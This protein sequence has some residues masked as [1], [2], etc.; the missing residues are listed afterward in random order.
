MKNKRNFPE[1][2]YSNFNLMEL[3]LAIAIVAATASFIVPILGGVEDESRGN[4]VKYE[5]GRLREAFEKLDADCVLSDD[6]LLDASRYGLWMLSRR[7]HPDDPSKD[8][9]SYDPDR[10]RGWRGPYA[11]EE[12]EVAVDSSAPGQPEDASAGVNVPVFKDPYSGY[13]RVL[14]PRNGEPSRIALVCVG[15]DGTLDTTPD[16]VD[17]FG[18]LKAGGDDMVVRLL[19][20]R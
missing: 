5:M 14:I 1:G 16:D 13:Y 7:N 18:N 6:S 11:K 19:P 2:R 3:L 15:P 12:G 9:P 8:I 17:S 20:N 4:V 10:G